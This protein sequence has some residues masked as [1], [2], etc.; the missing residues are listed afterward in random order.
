[1]VRAS[2][3]DV[4]HLE[5]HDDSDDQ[6]TET[7]AETTESWPERLTADHNVSRSVGCTKVHQGG[8]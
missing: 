5:R 2:M 8:D 3:D 4:M 7:A 6:Y 1:M